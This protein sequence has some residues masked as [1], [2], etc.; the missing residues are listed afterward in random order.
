MC[1]GR[2]LS[3]VV[4]EPQELSKVLVCC[5]HHVSLTFVKLLLWGWGGG[6]TNKWRAAL[7]QWCGPHMSQGK[8]TRHTGRA[9]RDSP[10]LWVQHQCMLQ[11]GQMKQGGERVLGWRG[12][13]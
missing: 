7:E 6:V 12:V 8:E 11:G 4:W 10:S 3:K 5:P 1:G 9:F 13:A 2:D